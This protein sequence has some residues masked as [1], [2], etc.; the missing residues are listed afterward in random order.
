TLSYWSGYPEVYQAETFTVPAG[1]ARVS[2]AA[3][4]QFTGQSSVLHFGLFDP[5]GTFAAYSE[6]QGLAD[7]GEV[8]VA[9]PA[10][11]TWTAVFFTGKDS[12]TTTG[13]F[14]TVQWDATM[15]K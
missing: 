12:G 1:T 13:T 2:L 7:Y 9:S 4:F 8:E 10:A 6:P 5:K 14:G 3:D 11:G 15:W